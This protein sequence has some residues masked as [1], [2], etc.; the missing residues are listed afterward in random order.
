MML[1]K[2]IDSIRYSKQVSLSTTIVLSGY[3]VALRISWIQQHYS[4]DLLLLWAP[5]SLQ[6]YNCYYRIIATNRALKNEDTRKVGWFDRSHRLDTKYNFLVSDLI[7][8]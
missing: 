6:R 2:I 5:L 4:G 7:E 3:S 1:L 8:A